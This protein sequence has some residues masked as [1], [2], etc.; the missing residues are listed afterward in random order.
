MN[1]PEKQSQDSFRLLVETASCMIVILREDHS[2]AYFNSF[3]ERLTGYS[4]EEVLGQDYFAIFLPDVEKAGVDVEFERVFAGGP[5]TRAYENA[6]RC[7]DDS[8]R[9]QE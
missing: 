5:A 9:A 2:I 8:R 7:R 3:A 6:I 1:L 4:A